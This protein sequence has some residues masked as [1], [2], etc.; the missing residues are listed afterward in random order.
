MLE[1]A[2]SSEVALSPPVS[3]IPLLQDNLLW[4][5]SGSLYNLLGDVIIV[6]EREGINDE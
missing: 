1:I 2:L 5:F 6:E 3:T 4:A